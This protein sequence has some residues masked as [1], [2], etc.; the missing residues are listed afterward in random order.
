[1]KQEFTLQLSPE[2]AY[3]PVVFQEVVRKKAELPADSNDALAR[4]VKRSIDARG[5]N[6]KVNVQ[7][8]LFV[9]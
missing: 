9:K 8:E 7:A 3:D 1:M 5:R 6:V 2:E 4:Q